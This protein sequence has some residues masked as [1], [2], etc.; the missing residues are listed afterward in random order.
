LQGAD[1][2][3]FNLR[4]PRI[5]QEAAAAKAAAQGEQVATLS[6]RVLPPKVDADSTPAEI[7]SAARK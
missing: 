3:E 2:A 4:K 1:G 7:R 6:E 5:I